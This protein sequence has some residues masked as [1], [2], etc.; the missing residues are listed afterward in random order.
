[1]N[2]PPT[3]SEAGGE[4]G[5]VHQVGRR[6]PPGLAA[7]L[8]EPADAPGGIAPSQPG[9]VR[10]GGGGGGGGGKNGGTKKVKYKKITRK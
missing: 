6:A 8:D 10:G 9:C 4:R 1:M 3:A 5:V 7:A 2:P